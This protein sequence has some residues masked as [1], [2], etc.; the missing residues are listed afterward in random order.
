MLI[1]IGHEESDV[2]RLPWVSIAIVAICILAYGLANA[3]EDRAREAA[4]EKLNEAVEFYFYHPYLELD[5]KLEDHASWW[6]AAFE[7]EGV[8]PEYGRARVDPF[9]RQQEQEELDQLT[10][11]WVEAKLDIP[12]YRYGLIPN[13]LQLGDLVASM[14]LHAGLMHL[15]GNLMFLWLSGPPLEDV[16]GR[17]VFAAF[18]LVSGIVGGLLWVARYSESSIPLVGASGAVAGLMGA[19]MIRFWSTKIRMFYFYFIGFRFFTGTFSSPAWVMLGL[20]FATELFW[21]SALDSTAGQFGG[22]ANL[23]HVGGFAFGAGTAWVIRELKTEEKVFQPKID[24]KL[25]EEANTAIEESHE[26]IQQGKT[27]EAWE[28]LATETKEHPGNYDASLALWDLAVQSGRAK[29]AQAAILQCIRMDLRRGENDLAAAHWTELTQHGSDVEIDFHFRIRLA[30]ALVEQ[31]R[32]EEAA[33]LLATAHEDLDPSLPLG[34]RVRLAR[35]AARS[36]SASA[37]ASCESVLSDPTLPEEIREDVSQLLI[38]ANAQGLRLPRSQEPEP[39]PKDA[40]LPLSEEAPKTRVLKVMPAVP[41][42][43]TGDRIAV[44]VTG[45]GPRQLPLENIQA[46]AAARID[47]GL[48]NAFVVIDLLVDS[49]WSDRTR[50]RTVRMSSTE[51]DARAIISAQEDPHQALVAFIDNLLAISGATPIPNAG[52]VKGMPFYSFASLPD[53]ESKVFGFVAG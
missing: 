35:A 15:I 3:Q 39:P 42:G 41:T 26:L 7:A 20:W 47:G 11:A 17:P 23:V 31:E 14:F 1:P 27:Q 52:A 9:Q 25:G 33:E 49:L 4:E 43:L 5:D 21:A 10:G 30:E 13:D 37:P 12:V 38:R 32:D 29:E 2:R 18:F 19:F 45:Q 50:I 16:W 34:I 22:V 46:V 48:Q 8:E 44:N 51:F 6:F 36:R 24:A 40:P 53:Y 28:L